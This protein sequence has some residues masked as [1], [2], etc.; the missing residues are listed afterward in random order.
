MKK[1]SLILIT[2][3]T[4]IMSGCSAPKVEQATPTSKPE[5]S[6][7]DNI[8]QTPTNSV[9][10]DTV[11]IGLDSDLQTLDP[12]NGYEVFGNFYFYS[13]YDNLYKLEGSNITEPQPCLAKEYFVDETGKEYTFTL[14]EDVKFASGN[15]FTSEDVVYSVN[16][17]I[18]LKGNTTPIIEN[19]A[20]VTAPDKYTVVIKLKEVD[21]SF[22]TKIASNAFSVLDSKYLEEQIKDKTSQTGKDV[23]AEFLDANSAGS[24]P[25]VLKS[26]TIKSEL[27]LE[28]NPNYWGTTPEINTVILKEIPDSNAQ[29]QMLERGEIDIALTIGPD[30]VALIKDKPGV[31][32]ISTPTAMTSFL[33]MNSS[34]EVSGPLSKKEVQQ[35]IRYA[36]DYE[37]LR[38]LAGDGA[39]IPLSFVPMGFVGALP[40]PDNYTNLD[41][42]KELMEQAGLKDGFTTTIKVANFDSEGMAWSTIAQKIK[43]DL[44]K[45]N[46]NVEIETSEIGVVIDEYRQGKSPFIV[47]HWEPDYYDL[48]N[49]LVFAPGNLVGLRA[50]WEESANPELAAIAKQIAAEMDNEKRKGLS[51]QMQKEISENSPY[52]FLIQHPKSFAVSDKLYD[53]YYNNYCKIQLGMLKFTD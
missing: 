32:V 22:L 19:V 37:G 12:A 27:I 2:V 11:V 50:N 33:L 16:R 30:Q 3:V 1:L 26:W 49:Q 41:K 21:S 35:A 7:S 43:D 36:I 20:E 44:A 25:Y 10:P 29:M 40:R 31:R 34:E 51:E 24:G 6:T 42:A 38:V 4:V 28:R 5:T 52:A 45:I 23:A 13:T 39:Q 53:V 46:I 18:N 47:M 8:G 15:E 17:T 48:N 14:R 9:K